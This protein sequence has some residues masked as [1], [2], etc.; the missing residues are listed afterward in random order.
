MRF[1]ADKLVYVLLLMLVTGLASAQEKRLALIIGNSDYKDSPLRNPINDA[2]DMA[3]ALED[4][5]FEVMLHTDADRRE[6]GR[7]IRDFGSKLKENRGVGLFYYA[8]HG[9]Q[10]ENSNFLIPVDT[11]LEEEDEVPYESVD[12]GSVLAKMESAGNALNLIILDACRNNPFPRRFRSTSRGLARVEAPI[13][14]LVV[15]AT[16]PGAVAADGEGRNGVFTG[17]L[18]EQLRTGGQSLTQTIRRTRAAVVEATNGQQVPWESSSL[19][20]DYYFAPESE[21]EPASS[22]ASD[23]TRPDP[24][25][26]DTTERTTPAAVES[27]T[28]RLTQSAAPPDNTSE[29]EGVQEGVNETTVPVPSSAAGTDIS[30]NKLA[31]LDNG[32]EISPQAPIEEAPQDNTRRDEFLEP[33]APEINTRP[34]NTAG[35][36]TL[37]VTVEPA[38]A[39]IRIMDIVDRYKPG[40]VLDNDRTYDLYITRKGYDS[41]REDIKLQDISTLLNISL[42]QQRSD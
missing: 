24:V 32:T 20:R 23:S 35:A 4:L 41:Y 12:V 36:S 14:S 19:L 33:D 6:M 40:M 38:D 34:A 30:D 27:R 22:L 13:G 15:Y 17:A 31:L 9:M 7:A 11:P 42:K 26:Q 29:Q 21:P 8:G 16:A 28:D 1:A 3:S 39:R 18:L 10:I 37:T 5:N 25:P 2:N